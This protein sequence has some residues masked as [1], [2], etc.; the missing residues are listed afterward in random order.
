MRSRSYFL[1]HYKSHLLYIS[2][3]SPPKKNFKKT[4]ILFV[5]LQLSIHTPIW[6]GRKMSI[7]LIW[8]NCRQSS[9]NDRNIVCVSFQHHTITLEPNMHR[10]L[11]KREEAE[12]G[13]T[14]AYYAFRQQHITWMDTS[15]R[16]S[17]K[18]LNMHTQLEKEEEEE[19][20]KQQ[21][22]VLFDW[23]I[24]THAHPQHLKR[25]QLT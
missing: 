24:S 14:N 1:S 2:S 13:T 25:M 12:R 6:K 18:E 5:L 20:S 10:Q 17:V 16:K 7:N 9:W 23:S 8:A 3:S 21:P 15:V 4:L 22:L 11:R 19:K